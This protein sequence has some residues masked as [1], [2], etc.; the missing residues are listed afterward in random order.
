MDVDRRL[1]GLGPFP[2]RLQRGMIEVLTVGVTVD[3]GAAEL[4]LA[5]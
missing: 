3:H 1:E 4:Q 5:H 2:E